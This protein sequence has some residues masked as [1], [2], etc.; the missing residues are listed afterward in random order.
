MKNL[1][2]YFNLILNFD[3]N[4]IVALDRCHNIFLIGALLSKKPENVLELGIGTAYVTLSL[5]HAI[6]Y[7]KKGKLTCVDNFLDWGGQK[8][9]WID[10][11]REAG[12][13]VVAPVEEK[14][15][16]S[17]CASDTYDF[18]ISDADHTNSGLW[19]NEHLRI[20]QHDGFM[21][22][23]DTNLHNT[24]LKDMFPNLVLVEK[25][26]KELGLPYYHFTDNSRPDEKCE[27]GWL[28]AINKK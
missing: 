10:K 2:E 16:V 7:N 14:E 19:V 18:L 27:R 12:V 8:P 13:N 24:N 1:Q 20:T 11:I 9:E 23:H 21:F 15:F 25:R 5:I 26:I 4:N 3:N 22:F 28:F 17:N 6:A